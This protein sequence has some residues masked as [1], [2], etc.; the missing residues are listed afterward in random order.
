MIRALRRLAL[1]QLP[2]DGIVGYG[3]LILLPLLLLWRALFAGEALFW[4]TPLLQFVP[5]QRLA[6]AMWRSGHLPLWNPLPGCGAPLAANYQS[7]VFYPLYALALLLP[8]EVALGW[9]MALHMALA[10]LAMAAWARAAGLER[11]PALLAA[12]ALEGSGFVVARAGLFPSI[13]V[14]FAWLPVW[15]WRAERLMQTP[16]LANALWLG[17]AVGLGLLAGHAQTAAYGLLLLVGYMAFRGSPI[18]YR[19]S[20]IADRLSSIADRGAQGGGRQS[21]P[22]HLPPCPPANLP[23]CPPANLPTCPPANLPT[24]PPANLP[25]CKLAHLPTCTLPLLLALSLAAVQLLPTAEL[26]PLS[27]RA[28]GVDREIGLT[29]SFW[30]WR[31]LTFFAPDMFGNPAHGNYWGY[32]NYW[33]DAAYVGLLPLLLALAA[34]VG[35]RRNAQRGAALFWSGVVIGSLFLALGRHNPVFLWLFDHVPF[36]DAFQSP[37]RWLALTTVGLAALAGIGAQRWR[38]GRANQRWGALGLVVG[39]AVALGG[40]AARYALPGIPASFGP[41][42][43]RLGL[44]LAACGG[45][46]LLRRETP[47]WRAAVLALLLLDLL[48]A[49]WGLAPT[50]DRAL[51]AG[52]SDTAATLAADPTFARVF[53]PYQGQPEPGYALKFERYFRFDSFG[54]RD[55]AFWAPI[56]Q[57]LLPNLAALDGLPSANNFDPLLPAWAVEVARASDSAPALLRAMGVTHLVTATVAGDIHM[58]ALPDSL[59]RAWVV[60]T[61]RFVPAGATLAALADSR[62][63]P[64]VE[65][66]LEADQGG[67]GALPPGG[68]PG[69]PGPLRASLAL[70]DGPNRVTIRAALDQPGYLVVADTWYPGWQARVD[71]QPAPLWRA[72]YAFRAVYLEAGEHTVEMVY[73]P[74][75]VLIGGAISLAAVGGLVAGLALTARKRRSS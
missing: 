67:G 75:L 40:L 27:P 50:V 64:A 38:R 46:A 45:V 5:W 18:A 61:A 31:L 72:N 58:T 42:T 73:R 70:H 3:A 8:A 15:L 35:L 4:G 71:G 25:T 20:S 28:S 1:R 62:F 30:P 55:L 51:Y 43:V 74:R 7:G 11:F 13:V 39:L 12:L 24:C 57:T 48:V 16:R 17:G 56:R 2:W 34:V 26:L 36:F 29:Y 60:P 23:T 59:G 53:W 21:P 41:A 6:A 69:Q 32:G 22:A 65:V 66:L 14:T 37:S 52:R 54:P 68:G 33:E 9:T 63:D 49:G 44:T 47:L 10:G 19:L